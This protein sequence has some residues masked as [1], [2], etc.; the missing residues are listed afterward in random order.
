MFGQSWIGVSLIV[1]ALPQSEPP[2]PTPEEASAPKPKFEKIEAGNLHNV[3]RCPKDVINGSAPETD[4]D[5]D[6]LKKMGIRTIISVDGMYPD[7]ERA[8]HHGLRYV[9]LPIGYDGIPDPQRLQLVK[10]VR[11]LPKPI[12]VH[13]HHGHH[14]SP[15]ATA[16][17]LVG[18]N[19]ITPREGLDLLE[20]AGTSKNYKGLYRDVAQAQTIPDH[21]LDE[22]ESHFPE[23]AAIP[24]MTEAMAQAGLIWDRFKEVRKAGWKT[25]Q[26]HP[27][28]IPENEAT[29]LAEIF[30]ELKRQDYINE[31]SEVERFKKFLDDA[32]RS[33]FDLARTLR[34]GDDPQREAAY[35]RV[36]EACLACH[37]VYRD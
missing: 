15:T 32:E 16:F 5:F 37:D 36:D 35:K 34:E 13:C 25:P 20:L 26:N 28:L 7:V 8:K 9:H 11:D 10:A 3:I 33:A 2:T 6:A 1:L 24:K 29:V 23:R 14:R 4:E 19:A 21:A 22:Q 12:Y 18:L 30:R 27:D 31:Y 17:L